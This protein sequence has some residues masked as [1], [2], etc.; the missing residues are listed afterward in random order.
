M[1]PKAISLKTVRWIQKHKDQIRLVVSIAGTVG[2]VVLIANE[3]MKV[4][5]ILKKEEEKKGKPLTLPEK[6]DIALPV[7]A[8]GIALLGATVCTDIYRFKVSKNTEKSLAGLYL[9][10]NTA[11]NKYRERVRNDYGPEADSKIINEIAQENYTKSM[12]DLHPELVLF[13]DEFSGRFFHSTLAAVQWAEY[14]FNRNFALRGDAPVNE[15]YEFLGLSPIEG[16]DVIGWDRY[17]GEAFYGYSFVDFTHTLKET[18]DGT[19]YYSIGTPFDPTPD[20]YDYSLM[21]EHYQ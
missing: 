10:S 6:V 3:T 4:N 20:C 13:Y 16:G 8:P 18:S 12:Y 9:M 21:D 14:N 2:S 5:D 19:K 15:F 11:Y 1:N 7:Y 17:I